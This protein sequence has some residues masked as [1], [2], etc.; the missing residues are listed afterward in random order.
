MENKEKLYK[1]IYGEN[2]NDY[3]IINEN[4]LKEYEKE[5]GF[6]SEATAF[7]KIF[8]DMVLSNNIMHVLNND[9]DVLVGAY[10]EEN[11]T[12][13]EE[14]QFFIVDPNFNDYEVLSKQVEAMNN[15]LYYSNTL[16]NYILGV[17]DLG[18]NRNY[19]LTDIKL[20]KMEA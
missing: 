9:V 12:Y 18:T 17:T 1:A 5:Q 15:T 11:D 3:F 14:Y 6:L 2:E 7:R 16:D 20:E 8:S 13:K 10:D 4:E 19:V